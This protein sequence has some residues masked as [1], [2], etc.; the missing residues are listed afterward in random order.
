MKVIRGSRPPGG[1]GEAGLDDRIRAAETAAYATYGVVGR[2][3]LVS[4]DTGAGQVSVRLT[5]FG[6]EHSEQPPVLLLHGIG[7]VTVLAAPLLA[8]LP[9]RRVIALDWPGHGLSGPCV[10]AAKT[11]IRRHAVTTIKALLD[12]LGIDKV[13]VVGHSL[14]GQFALYAGLDLPDRVRRLALLGAPGA[15]FGGVKPLLAMVIAAVPRLGPL[16][17]SRRLNESMFVRTSEMALGKGALDAVPAGLVTAGT[18]IAHRPGVPDSLASFFRALLR[19]RSV[20]TGVALIFDEL[21]TLTQPALLVWGDQDVF[22]APT[23]AASSITSIRDCH[24]LRLLDA[25]HAPW[26]QH[27]ALVGAA[28]ARHLS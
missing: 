24:L 27:D 7:S 1:G 8:H 22:L 25:G 15:G 21:G 17:L 6:P 14:G 2:E 13:D 3:Q 4:V 28:V 12:Q 18:L 10:L 5:L 20:R 9:G 26:L 23:G 11:N 19:G 16:L